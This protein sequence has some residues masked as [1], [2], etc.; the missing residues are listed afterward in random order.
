MGMSRLNQYLYSKRGRW[1]YTRR[2]PSDVAHLDRRGTIRIG[3][4]TAS[5]DVARH[6]R[7]AMMLADEEYWALLQ[8]N[9]QHSAPN[10]Q[11]LSRYQAAKK[12]AMARGYIYTPIDTLVDEASLGEIMDR[13]ATLKV[14]PKSVETI[15]AE[16][17]LGGVEETHMPISQAFALY[18]DTLCIG[19]LKGKS[20]SQ[21]KTWRKP[22]ERALA[23][24]IALF[25]DLP[26]DKIT[27]K[28]GQDFYKWWGERVNPSD[29]SKGLNPNSAN[30][31]IGNIR[32]LFKSYWVYQGDHNRPNP[33]KG[34]NY[35]ENYYKDIPA[36]ENSWV[37]EKILVPGLFKGLNQDARLIIY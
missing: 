34:L 3:L 31:D 17:L 7:D 20:D 22:K 2:V 28:H 29:G 15:E 24:F 10:G 23:N 5:L 33:F 14:Q 26:M 35:T 16:A 25:G 36:F 9:E 21:K 12:R 30:R 11:L 6:R 18:T 8:R 1:Q 4:K 13:I 37:R 32:T 27:R 19:V